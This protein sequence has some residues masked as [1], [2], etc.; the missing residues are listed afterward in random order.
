M[1]A[2]GQGKPRLAAG[3]QAATAAAAAAAA[4][5]ATA[6]VSWIEDCIV[7]AVC[8]LALDRFADYVSDQVLH[9]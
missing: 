6:N 1:A 7:R 4:A 5:S 2:E 3:Q 8:V 9:A